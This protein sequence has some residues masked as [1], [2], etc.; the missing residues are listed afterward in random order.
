[1]AA[2]ATIKEIELA[3]K[4]D[5]FYINAVLKEGFTQKIKEAVCS[6]APTQFSFY[7]QI[8]KKRA[9]FFPKTLSKMLITYTVTYDLLKKQYQVT[10]SV[11]GKEITSLSTDDWDKMVRWVSELRRV[12]FPLSLIWKEQADYLR[13]KAEMK[14][15]KLPFP[16]NYL[17]NII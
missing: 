7:L 14:C 15:I 9:I 10:Q 13:I 1:M 5:F 4:G 11:Q 12:E 17:F 8:R 16:L 6:G 3:V 2:K